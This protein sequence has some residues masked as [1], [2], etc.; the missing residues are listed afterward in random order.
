MSEPDTKQA[1]RKEEFAIS[2]D[3]LLAE[4]KRLVA[5]G[6]V[7]RIIIK[8]GEKTLIEVPLTLGV[9]GIALLPVWAAIGA[10]AA[11]VA[12]MTIVIERTD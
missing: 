5:E 9:I 11:L 3:K 2:G 12:K 6:N 1:T 10:V 8:Q 4:I 7:R